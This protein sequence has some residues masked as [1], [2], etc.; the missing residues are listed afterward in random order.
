MVK[1]QNEL[2]L[3]VV[4]GYEFEFEKLNVCFVNLIGNALPLFGRFLYREKE[5]TWIK[6]NSSLMFKVGWKHAFT[7]NIE[8]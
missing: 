4:T 3:C 7:L 2:F 5:K 6:K 8:K 1:R